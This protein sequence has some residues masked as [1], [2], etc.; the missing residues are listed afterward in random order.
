M[1]RVKV[2]KRTCIQIIKLHPVQVKSTSK[3]IILKFKKGV[4]AMYND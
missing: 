4:K 1:S 2:R 3:G